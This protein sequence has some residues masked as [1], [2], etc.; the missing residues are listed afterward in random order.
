MIDILLSTYNG[1]KYLPDQ[2]ESLLSQT[3]TDW[4]L[5]I[6]DDG[7]N[8]STIQYIETLE[9]KYPDKIVFIKDDRGNLGPSQSFSCL[10]KSS[11]A[12]YVAF[13]DQDDIWFSNKLELQT[14]EMLL[15][16][17]KLGKDVPILIH[18]DLM[19]VDQNMKV[20]SASF[21]KYQKLNPEKMNNIETLLVQ[22]YVTGCTC[23]LNRKLIDIA[24]P[25][26]KDAIMHDWWLAIIAVSNGSIIDISEPTIYYRQHNSNDVG[27]KAWGVTYIYELVFK[28]FSS[29]RTALLNT[30]NQAAALQRIECLKEPNRNLIKRYVSLYEMGWFERHKEVFKLGLR[31]YGFIR[32]MAFLFLL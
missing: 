13:C 18:S 32:N 6:R 24:V 31:K 20:L 3:F 15:Q 30:R 22:N 5:L 16:E 11:S 7:S 27:A 12:P 4:R 10:L 21:W 25:I 8:D 14:K 23:L 1:E 29:I 9:K 28:S 26:R 17:E 2:I 19:V